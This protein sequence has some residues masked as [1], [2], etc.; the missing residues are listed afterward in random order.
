LRA[1]SGGCC[2]W[3]GGVL[4]GNPPVLTTMCR[5]ES[6]SKSCRDI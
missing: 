2:C 4:K 1:R 3:H 5:S 6:R